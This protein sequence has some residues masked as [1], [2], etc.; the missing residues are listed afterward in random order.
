MAH[1]LCCKGF[2]IDCTIFTLY[3]ALLHH[4]ELVQYRA[5]QMSKNRKHTG[6]R[7]TPLVIKGKIKPAF[8]LIQTV[9]DRQDDRECA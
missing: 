7:K 2:E 8:M 3:T 5:I 4:F 6:R 1:P 9:S